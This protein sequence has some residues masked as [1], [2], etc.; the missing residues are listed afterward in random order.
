MD[1]K[2][3]LTEKEVYGSTTSDSKQ[4]M[5]TKKCFEEV[6]EFGRLYDAQVWQRDNQTFKGQYC[7]IACY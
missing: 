5:L 7:I 2:I 6:Q 3:M 1:Y 4:Y